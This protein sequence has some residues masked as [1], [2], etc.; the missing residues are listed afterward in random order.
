[1][2]AA[3][4]NG[5]GAA[6]CWLLPISVA[7]TSSFVACFPMQ[8]LILSTTDRSSNKPTP[9]EITRSGGMNKN[10][11]TWVTGYSILATGIFSRKQPGAAFA[12]TSGWGAED[13][14]RNGMSLRRALPAVRGTEPRRR[15]LPLGPRPAG[16]ANMRRRICCLMG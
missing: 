16:P 7:A 5:I 9:P 14:S 6:L 8:R 1:M 4:P 2:Q 12:L 15:G 11:Y 13:C 3:L 10:I